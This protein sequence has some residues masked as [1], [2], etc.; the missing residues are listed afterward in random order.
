MS[1][2]TRTVADRLK[3]LQLVDSDA[4]SD[5]H[6]T[7][8]GVRGV[9]LGS[10]GKEGKEIGCV[11][12]GHCRTQIFEFPG[13]HLRPTGNEL[14][15]T[16]HKC[17]SVHACLTSN[18]ADYFV[19][20]TD[21][22][23]YAIDPTLRHIVGQIPQKAALKQEGLVP[24]F[25]V[26]EESNRLTPT[27][28]NNCI[29]WEEMMVL[30]GERV[31]RLVGGREEEEF[32]TAVPTTGGVWPKIPK[33][34]QV[35]NMILAG[36]RVGQQTPDPIQKYVDLECLL[37]DDSR[38]VMMM[39]IEGEAKGTIVTEMGS[40]AFGDRASEISKAIF[41]MEQDPGIP[42]LTLLF[43]SMYSDEQKDDAYL[44]LHYLQLWQSLSEAGSR[45]LEYHGD[46]KKDCV[47]VGGRKTLLELAD[48]RD[49]IAHWWT[50][51]I[52]GNFLADLQRTINEL[53]RR[54]YFTD[55]P[56][57]SQR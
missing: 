26:I 57:T 53:I 2:K 47:A 37:T 22:M 32:I 15:H 45:Y 7:E 50:D 54:K 1:R 28:M 49:D 27:H 34:Q 44:R 17:L 11:I 46:I 36:V 19:N 9:F 3:A 39:T 41:N 31:P 29:L 42:H 35:I 38:F 20:S 56:T 25:L 21:N 23:H 13:I 40:A 12:D 14:H 55:P 18:L 48:Y 8:A 10:E 24:V 43:N 33:N 4:G 51:T 5:P 30:D 52:D 6:L 16:I